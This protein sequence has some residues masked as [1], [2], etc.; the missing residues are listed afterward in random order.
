MRSKPFPTGV[1]NVTF[2]IF[3]GALPRNHRRS[4]E[5][6][7]SCQRTS[8]SV[9]SNSVGGQGRNKYAAPTAPVVPQPASRPVHWVMPEIRPGPFR[10]ENTK[11]ESGAT[12]ITAAS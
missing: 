10:P 11:Q 2:F 8:P 5:F 12:S 6:A 1:N 4:G 9:R 7:V 3:V